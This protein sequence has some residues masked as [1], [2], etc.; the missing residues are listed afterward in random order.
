M[1]KM[2]IGQY[3]SKIGAKKRVAVPKKFRELMGDRLIVTRGY[4]GCLVL[5]DGER[6]EEITKN[7]VGGSFIDKKIRDTSRFL[8]AGAHD[9]E[10]DDQGRFVIPGGLHGY[11]SLKGK[12]IFIG[13]V[14]WVEIWSE[15]KWKDQEEHIRENGSMVA[16]ELAEVID[17][18]TV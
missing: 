3:S 6:W 12:A 5:V 7:V 11:A 2:L 13:L 8:L 15:D 18:Q 17:M 14:N 1:T 4:E 16:Q 9:V 10:L